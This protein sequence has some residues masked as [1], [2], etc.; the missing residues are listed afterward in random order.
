MP[1]GHCRRL[2]VGERGG[3]ICHVTVGKMS[4]TAVCGS[5]VGLEPEYSPHMLHHRL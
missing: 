4:T 5:V 2:Q 3:E 1:V